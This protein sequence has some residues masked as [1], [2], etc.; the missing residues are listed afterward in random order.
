VRLPTRVSYY[1]YKTVRGY[2]P[3]YCLANALISLRGKTLWRSD[4]DLRS[5]EP[6]CELPYEKPIGRVPS[7]IIARV[8]RLGADSAA[9]LDDGQLLVARR[10]T[11]YRVSLETGAWSVD[12]T[13]PDGA[14]I[15]YLSAVTDPITGQGAVCFG[16]YATRFDGGP[17]N[18]WRRG[19]APEDR[20]AITGTFPPGEIDHVHN[21]CQMADGS[22]YVLSGDFGDAA[23]IWK[24]SFSLSSFTAIARGS[25][26]VRACW[27]WQSP[28]GPLFF[29][30]DSQF[31]LNHLRQI[32]DDHIFDVA[33]IIG[34][35]IHAQ[36]DS[37]R[38]MF[39]TAVEPGS[40]SGNRLR[41]VLD[42][43]P[44]PGIMTP[45]A[46]IYLLYQ[47]ALTEVHREAKDGWPMRL[48]QFGT[49]K[50]PAGRMP[51]DRFFAF[52]IGVRRHDGCCL[53]FR[54]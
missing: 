11:I 46:A 52:G 9:L 3:L 25:Q 6:F 53:L 34:S 42:R 41:D 4:L 44:G 16:E 39:S 5:F 10:S 20:W 48:A 31:E 12:L 28:E 38:L 1:L 36:G 54:Q 43:K 2:Q 8:F 30:T 47:G 51:S 45:E 32:S 35:S 26:E 7:R 15:L 33:P 24:T 23:A 49:F 18:V 50:F 14:R 37:E 27:L 29:A 40:L 19:L 21:I 17:I 13:V 22:I